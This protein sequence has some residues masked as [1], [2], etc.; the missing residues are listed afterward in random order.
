MKLVLLPGMDGTGILFE[1]LLS[2]LRGVDVLVLPLPQHGP[3]DY[4]SLSEDVSKRLPN[5]DFILV[6]ESF[7]GGIGAILSQS[8]LLHM[9]GIIFVASFLSAPKRILAYVTSF[10]PL[11]YL[12]QLPFSSF[13]YSF[14]F[15][16][17]EA[18]SKE[19]DEFTNVIRYVPDSILRFR[20]KVIAGSKY[21]RFKSHIPS[22]Y[23]GATRDMLVHSKKRAEFKEAYPGITFIDLEG[24]HFILQANPNVGAAA[25]LEAAKRLTSK[26][27]GAQTNRCFERHVQAI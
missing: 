27:N 26:S 24:P 17:R 8:H 13:V 14:F 11:S 20:L 25:I 1:S 3:Q 5:E 6:A 7:S 4:K 16:G 15:L 22:V 23:I 2:E 18:G 19:I 12:I 21:T 9:K 10:M